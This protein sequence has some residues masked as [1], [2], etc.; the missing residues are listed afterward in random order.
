ML[1]PHPSKSLRPNHQAR[2]QSLL[3]KLSAFVFPCTGKPYFC[4]V[5]GKSSVAQL[6]LGFALIAG[7]RSSWSIPEE[8]LPRLLPRVFASMNC[9]A[10]SCNRASASLETR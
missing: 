9:K 4:K 6:A 3:W 1:I 8:S 10:G 7:A 5:G 2:A